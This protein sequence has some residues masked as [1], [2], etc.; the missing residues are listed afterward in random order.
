MTKITE[1]EHF[2]FI[3]ELAVL[4]VCDLLRISALI[5]FVTQGTFKNVDGKS[6]FISM[7]LDVDVLFASLS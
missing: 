3:H 7:V 1:F 2:D 4:F 5:M 6:C